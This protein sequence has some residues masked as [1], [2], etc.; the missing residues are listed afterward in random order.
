MDA[1]PFKKKSPR[2][3]SL[4]HFRGLQDRLAFRFSQTILH[5]SKILTDEKFAV[6]AEIESSSLNSI[7]LENFVW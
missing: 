4:R 2:A 5:S 1:S 3:E 7:D 6:F